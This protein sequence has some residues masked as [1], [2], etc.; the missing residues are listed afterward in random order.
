MAYFDA[1][2]ICDDYEDIL[3]QTLVFQHIRIV[4][5]DACIEQIGKLL[6]SLRGALHARVWHPGSVVVAHRGNP[7]GTHEIVHEVIWN[8][9]NKCLTN[10]YNL[11]FRK[12]YEMALDHVYYALELFIGYIDK[13]EI[14]VSMVESL[15]HSRQ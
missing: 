6:S 10:S 3:K 1:S 7:Y 4:G 2:T 5:G 14:Q 12:R 8:N 13:F 11:F 9:L 15:R